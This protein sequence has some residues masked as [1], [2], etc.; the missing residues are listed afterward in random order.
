LNPDASTAPG[1]EASTIGGGERHI[2]QSEQVLE[3]LRDGK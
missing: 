3:R 2:R 1:R